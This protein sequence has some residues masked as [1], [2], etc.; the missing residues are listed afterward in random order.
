[1]SLNVRFCEKC[2]KGYDIGIEF[3]LCSECR[4]EGR[5]KDGGDEKRR[6]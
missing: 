2:G 4:I 3:A 6:I 5:I 1:M